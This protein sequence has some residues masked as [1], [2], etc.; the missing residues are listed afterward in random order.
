MLGRFGLPHRGRVRWTGRSAVPSWRIRNVHERL[1]VSV[2]S[3]RVA[4]LLASL[5]SPDDRV[6]PGADWSP[7]VLDRPLSEGASGG[8]GNVRYTCGTYLPGRLIEFT[9]DSVHGRVVDGRHVFEVIPRHA[10]ILVRHTLDLECGFVDWLRLITVVVPAH[11]AVLEQLL[12][13]LEYAV[14][15]TIR[16]RYRWNSR[17]RFI[18]RSFG[19]STTMSAVRGESEN[20]APAIG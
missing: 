2:L 4:E 7:M 18:R 9:F 17:V 15:G 19:L 16:R 5:G 13:N 20:H 14:T 3:E 8:H 1:L 10:G 6:W 12:D 11:D